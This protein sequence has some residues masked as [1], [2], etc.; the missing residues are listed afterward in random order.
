ML[1]AWVCTK[2]GY[3]NTGDYNICTRCGMWRFSY[4]ECCDVEQ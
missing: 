4:L 2:C 3:R 1:S